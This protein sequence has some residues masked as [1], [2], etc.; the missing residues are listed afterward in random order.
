MK[1]WPFH[2]ILRLILPFVLV[3]WVL[4]VSYDADPWDRGWLTSLVG[5][6]LRPAP[7]YQT[8]PM[9]PESIEFT[10]YNEGDIYVHLVQPTSQK[11]L[12]VTSYTGTPIASAYAP[13]PRFADYGLIYCAISTH[14][15][16]STIIWHVSKEEY[17]YDDQTLED[18]VAPDRLA[19]ASSRTRPSCGYTGV[20]PQLS[21]VLWNRMPLQSSRTFIAYAPVQLIGELLYYFTFIWWLLTLRYAKRLWPKPDGSLCRHCGY[22]TTG[23]TALTCPECGNP[24]AQPA[25][26]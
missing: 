12:P 24:I 15:A 26:S 22:P 11:D 9:G 8:F 13:P 19:L 17:G 14:S 4:V 16:S 6:I 1:R 10:L 20:S 21:Q 18:L 2:P 3:A 7:S 23:L 25:V 5:R